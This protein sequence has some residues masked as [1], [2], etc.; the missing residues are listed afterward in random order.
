[1]IKVSIDTLIKSIVVMTF[2]LLLLSVYMVIKSIQEKAA[3]KKM[4]AY[5]QST[6]DLWYR[7]L[8]GEIA[9]P[10]ELI[11]SNDIE[12]E[13]IEE[14]FLSY[15]NNISNLCIKDKIRV[16][17][18]Q[19]LREHYL[20][21]LTSK[22]WSLRM[23]AL[24][25][26]IDFEIDSLA[27]ECRN[28]ERKTKLS[29][30]EH[31]LL[32]V[33]R[34]MF[35][36]TGFV[37]EFV[38]LSSKLSEYEFKKLLIGFSHETLEQ[39]TYQMNDL[40]ITYQYY[41]IDILGVIRSL[42]FLPFLEDKLGDE[43]PEIR[44]RSLKAIHEIGVATDLNK[45]KIFLESPKWEERLMLAKLL[46]AFSLEQVYPYLEQLL[47]DEN[48]WVRYHAA[49]TIGNSKDGKSRLETFITTAKDQYAIEMAREVLEGVC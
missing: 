19:Y 7:Y 49:Q 22:K 27:T 2:V 5:M 48:W 17:S 47:Q 30:G 32:L 4:K 16:F 23:N 34:S 1:M 35:D 40:P 38:S 25:R 41:F 6:L 36:E 29:S 15:I 13:A 18:N 11:P 37:K 14:I 12:I 3:A 33:I 10:K 21:L 39:L 9:L 24:Y 42:D 8:N 31:F 43:K 20:R 45:Y 44:I 26:I 46:G 28:M